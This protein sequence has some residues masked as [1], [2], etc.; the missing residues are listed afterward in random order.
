MFSAKGNDFLSLP[1]KMDFFVHLNGTVTAKSRDVE[2]ETWCTDIGQSLSGQWPYDRV[3][4]DIVVSMSHPQIR[5]RPFAE[6]FV[7]VLRRHIL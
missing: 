7:K 5:F 1:L 6:E 3:G 2:F 4:C